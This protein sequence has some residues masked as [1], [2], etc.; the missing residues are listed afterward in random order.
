M[1]RISTSSEKADNRNLKNDRTNDLKDKYGHLAN[2][3]ASFERTTAC[4]SRFDM[5]NHSPDALQKQCPRIWLPVRQDN[6]ILIL[7]MDLQMRSLSFE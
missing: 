7:S 2:K 4:G 6:I 1:E 3:F 5:D